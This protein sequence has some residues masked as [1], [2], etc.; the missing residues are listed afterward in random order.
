[1]LVKWVSFIN[2]HFYLHRWILSYEPEKFPSVF[3]EQLLPAI[4][5]L[6][7]GQ[8]S[9]GSPHRALL[10]R[11]P[12]L[13]CLPAQPP[14]PAQPR[15]LAPIPPPPPSPPS[16]LLAR[17]CYKHPELSLPTSRCSRDVRHSVR[18]TL[19]LAAGA[20]SEVAPPPDVR[21][22]GAGAQWLSLW[23]RG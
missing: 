14:P 5:L 16:P 9:V 4:S 20:V 18:P 19:R 23:P 17:R 7:T 2:L 21:Q 15:C 11:W 13:L 6:H 10:S 12:L 8:R 3:L 1:M 22:L